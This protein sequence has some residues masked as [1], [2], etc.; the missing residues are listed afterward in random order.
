MCCASATPIICLYNDWNCSC[1]CSFQL[2]PVWHRWEA[3]CVGVAGKMAGGSGTGE[4]HPAAGTAR[5]YGDKMPPDY[6]QEWL[7]RENT[8]LVTSSARGRSLWRQNHRLS[9]II[10]CLYTVFLSP[11]K[12]THHEV[13]PSSTQYSLPLLHLLSFLVSAHGTS[14][15][16]TTT[17]MRAHA[18]APQHTR[19]CGL[20][21]PVPVVS[22]NWKVWKWNRF[23][24]SGEVFKVRS[25]T[26]IPAVAV[27]LCRVCVLLP[28]QALCLAGLSSVLWR[29]HL[30]VLCSHSLVLGTRVAFLMA[31]PDR[32]CPPHDLSSILSPS[33]PGHKPPTLV[34][35]VWRARVGCCLCFAILIPVKGLEQRK[36]QAKNDLKRAKVQQ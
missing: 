21:T 14:H 32:T 31:W 18:W 23:C 8:F 17:Q 36:E 15:R 12:P 13:S 29:I 4:S 24:S 33:G 10:C 9:T 3:L 7:P 27:L 26:C 20:Q 34:T 22:G 25:L 2:D 35:S 19:V 30:E 28:H 1:K 6:W 16:C 11:G 5:L